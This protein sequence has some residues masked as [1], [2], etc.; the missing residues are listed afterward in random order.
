[1]HGL[2]VSCGTSSIAT[3]A[4]VSLAGDIAIPAESPSLQVEAST[5]TSSSQ[6]PDPLCQTP[7]VSSILLEAALSPEPGAASSTP[8]YGALH[9]LHAASSFESGTTLSA[10]QLSRTTLSASHMQQQPASCFASV[11]V[12]ASFWPGKCTQKTF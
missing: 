2:P 4:G 5:T 8:Q 12:V 6:L 9:H 3:V 10:S 1:M 11:T 7:S